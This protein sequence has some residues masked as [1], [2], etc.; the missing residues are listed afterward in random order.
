M[1]TFEL[2]RWSHDGIEGEAPGLGKLQFRP[3]SFNRITFGSGSG[4]AAEAN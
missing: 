3:N 2:A 4:P 1:L